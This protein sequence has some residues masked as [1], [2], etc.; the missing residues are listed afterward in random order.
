[1]DNSLPV[2][3]SHRGDGE[4]G[5]RSSVQANSEGVF[6]PKGTWQRKGKSRSPTQGTPAAAPS[7]HGGSPAKGSPPPPRRDPDVSQAP[8]WRPDS[9][10]G[11]IGGGSDAAPT[12]PHGRGGWGDGRPLSRGR[13]DEKE[14]RFRW[15]QLDEG[16]T[17]SRNGKSRQPLCKPATHGATLSPLHRSGDAGSAVEKATDPGGAMPPISPK[18]SSKLAPIHFHPQVTALEPVERQVDLLTMSP[19]QAQEHLKQG[20]HRRGG[21][22]AQSRRSTLS[23]GLSFGETIRP[24]DSFQDFPASGMVSQPLPS[25]SQ[26]VDHFPPREVEGPPPIREGSGSHM[27][28]RVMESSEVLNSKLGRLND[29]ANAVEAQQRA[30]TNEIMR[31]VDSGLPGN[32]SR[33]F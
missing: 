9:R 14:T 10:A 29:Q 3:Y 16:R 5:V 22:I 26:P 2:V 15:H 18:R 12:R 1:M 30:R 17:P 28:G 8:A 6:R 7:E 20:R 13:W 31:Q 27:G 24:G 4:P 33:H 21:S 23:K 32:L 19:S 25:S 11:S